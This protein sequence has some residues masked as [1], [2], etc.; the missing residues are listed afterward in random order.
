MV[1]TIKRSFRSYN[2]RHF[3]SR[4]ARKL[5]E[6]NSIQLHIGYLLA[7]GLLVTSLVDP[8]VS[9]VSATQ[10]IEQ[11]AIPVSTEKTEPPVVTETTLAW[12]VTHPVITQG[13]RFGHWGIDIQD[14]EIK[15]IYPADEGWISEV[16]DWKW[17][18]GKHVRIQHPNGRSSL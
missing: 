7:S 12:P 9:T 14:T 16:N 13:F 4:W 18:Y 8:A 1:S 5:F 15:D 3:A 6:R 2:G 10:N 17:G 11:V